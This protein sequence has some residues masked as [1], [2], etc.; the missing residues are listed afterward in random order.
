MKNEFNFADNIDKT[1]ITLIRHYM[2]EKGMDSADFDEQLAKEINEAVE[3]MYRKYVPRAVR[4]LFAQESFTLKKT[5]A[6]AVKSED[7][8]KEVENNGCMVDLDE[9]E[10][11]RSMSDSEYSCPY[12][13]L[14]DEYAVV[15]KQN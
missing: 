11:Y 2:A 7:S 9:D 6:P 1:K 5:V 12:Y 14:D 13:R 4:E 15:R 3:V 10:A 8:R